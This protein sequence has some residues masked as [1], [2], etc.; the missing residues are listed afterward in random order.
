[1]N[2]FEL[3][4]TSL[5][6]DVERRWRLFFWLLD[7][8]FRYEPQEFCK[9]GLWVDFLLPPHYYGE[10]EWDAGTFIEIK[11]AQWRST[12]TGEWKLVMNEDFIHG[13]QTLLKLAK[14]TKWNYKY[15]L[16]VGNPGMS[17]YEGFQIL[18]PNQYAKGIRW[19]WC[20]ICRAILVDSSEFC[21]HGSGGC[22]ADQNSS[23]LRQVFKQIKIEIPFERHLE[24]T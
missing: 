22:F 6:S 9:R 7:M 11:A 14:Y 1:M 12:S 21:V 19:G 13:S 10:G 23:Q 4:P 20:D 24:G 15:Y 2:E 18:K 8:K 16:I 5:R 17:A 3:K